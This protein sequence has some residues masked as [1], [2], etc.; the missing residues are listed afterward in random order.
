MKQ[1]LNR[2][3]ICE[4]ISKNRL[5]LKY[6]KPSKPIIID[7]RKMF[8]EDYARIAGMMPDGSLIKDLKRIYFHQKKYKKMVYTFAKLLKNLFSPESTILFKYGSRGDKQCY[9]NSQTLAIYFYNI[10]KIPKSDEQ[11][12]IPKWIF[13][14]KKSIKIAYLQ[15]A[16]D[17]EGTVL[18]KLTE[19][20][21][22]TKD[23]KF[24]LDLKKLLSQIEIKS[25]LTFAPRLKQKSGQHRI[26]IYSKE[27][28]KK[29]KEIGFRIPFLKNR[30]NNLVKKYKLTED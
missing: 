8:N 23:G 27:N 10:I 15:M 1:Q 2:L 18:K 12:R 11:M 13:K 19:I 4:K 25:S 5:K 22:G 3:F 21:F 26:S 9:I 29:F 14:A 20:R 30:F 7:K 6:N 28:F 17:M 24:A 16:F